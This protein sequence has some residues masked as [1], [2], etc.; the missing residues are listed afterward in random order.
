MNTGLISS[1][2]GQFVEP[3]ENSTRYK[4]G[5]YESLYNEKLLGSLSMKNGKCISTT[6]FLPSNL[7]PFFLSLP[8]RF[9]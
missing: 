9:L 5:S 1:P 2:Y 4:S 6:I 7:A 3:I 8:D